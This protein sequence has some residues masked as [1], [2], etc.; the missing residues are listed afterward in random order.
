MTHEQAQ[1]L[2][3]HLYQMMDRIASKEPILDQ[4]EAIGR[5]QTE[6]ASTAPAQ[7]KHF[8]DRRSYAKALEF[9]QHGS[10][11]EDPRRPDCDEEEAHP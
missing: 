3:T 5:I 11:I 8:L 7:L 6:I 10:I 2:Q 1:T 4:L 9:L